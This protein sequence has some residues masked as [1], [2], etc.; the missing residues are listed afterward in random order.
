[1]THSKPSATKT[2]NTKRLIVITGL[3]FLFAVIGFSIWKWF[4]E[5]SIQQLAIQK[6]EFVAF[7]GQFLAHTTFTLAIGLIPFIYDTTIRLGHIGELWKRLVTL[8]TILITAIIFWQLRI[9]F[10]QTELQQVF[11]D[12]SLALGALN[13]QVYLLIGLISGA[14]LTWI[15]L[16]SAQNIV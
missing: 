5:L 12:S 16:R 9:Q 7:S 1:M 11:V 13:F 14:C 10:L 4:F 15:T 3:S 6:L 8:S 2:N